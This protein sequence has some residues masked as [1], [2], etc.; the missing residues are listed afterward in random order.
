MNFRGAFLLI[1]IVLLGA[2]WSRATNY[3]IAN[4]GNDTA[5]GTSPVTPW[6]SLNKKYSVLLSAGDSLLLKGGDVFSGFIY[7]SPEEY[8]IAG[9][10]IF[11]GSYDG[12]RATILSGLQPAIF[13]YNTAGIS[14]ANLNLTG[15]GDST[16]SASGIYAYVDTPG[17]VTLHQLQIDSID[18]SGFGN[19][20]VEIQSYPKDQSRSGFQQVRLTHVVAH[21][22][23]KVGIMVWGNFKNT[24]SGYNHQNVYIGQC[25]AYNNRGKG[26]GISG[27]GI[28]LSQTDS[29]TIEY[30]S[31]YNNGTTGSGGVGIWAWDA[32]RITIQHCE[33]R[34]NHTT[35]SDGDGFDLDGGTTNSVMQYNYSHDNDG[36][37][38]LLWQFDGAR[39]FRTNVV[40]YNIS[41]ND[42]RKHNGYYGMV[43]MGSG[44]SAVNTGLHDILIY[45]NTLFKTRIPGN[46]R[47]QG[48]AISADG[49]IIQN[50]NIFNNI[51]SLDGSSRFLY[52]WHKADLHFL[53]NLYSSTVGFWVTEPSGDYISLGQW[54]AATGQ[55]MDSGRL[56]ALI[57]N[58]L[59]AAP[60]AAGTIG[61]PNNL[62]LL[63][64]S[65]GP[66]S[67]S[68][69]IDAGLDL[70]RRFGILVGTS[71]CVGGRVPIGAGFD[72]GAIEYQM[73]NAI[74][75]AAATAGCKLFPNPAK[76]WI[77]LEVPSSTSSTLM[78]IR[79]IAGRLQRSGHFV[80]QTRV[81]VEDLPAG[82]YFV[83]LQWADA[84]ETL[85]F[86]KE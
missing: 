30:C 85:R 34:H 50:V 79:D 68:P 45:N 61:N 31:A 21:D 57:G 55:E 9:K 26:A 42:S 16:N 8:G 72:I 2:N 77:T 43:A 14:I 69:V 18:V 54:A 28:E 17:N 73:P 51:F 37:G 52:K 27:S 75:V 33:S 24:D 65:Y 83:Q 56:G 4:N 7:L 59:L 62:S 1:V 22:N 86:Y 66:K 67:G 10:P 46:D 78:S 20:G 82:W 11:I 44:D 71:D 70:F 58:P 32:N 25:A 40:R 80:G 13:L 81:G 35:T 23:G 48:P 5:L 41:E 38:F 74:V 6:K 53:A 49:D 47:F 84:A 39:P 12:G 76:A 15:S 29:A 60:G 3:Y 36:T 63:S 19:A 64:N